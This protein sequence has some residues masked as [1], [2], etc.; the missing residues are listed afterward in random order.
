MYT[1]DAT[2]VIVGGT[3]GI[4]QSITKQMI[5]RGA[6]HVVLLSRSAKVSEEIKKLM[7]FG[8]PLGAS[9]HVKSCDAG[10]E[11]SVKS[12]LQEIQKTLPPIRG[13][14]HAAMVLRV[15]SHTS[16]PPFRLLVPS[17]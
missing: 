5:E 6:R 2:Y 3:G 9:V 16:R 11:T 4:G 7:D 14:V 13:I 15:S 12:V 17:Y 8:E 1:K 10:D